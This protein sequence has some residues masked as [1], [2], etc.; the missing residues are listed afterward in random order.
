MRWNTIYKAG[1]IYKIDVINSRS[2]AAQR[3]PHVHN[4]ISK[5]VLMFSDYQA[6][7]FLEPSKKIQIKSL[8]DSGKYVE[9]CNEW[10]ASS[11]RLST[12]ATQ[13]EEMS[14]PW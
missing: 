2:Q 12:R 10:W 13:Q 8:L 9:A 11:A 4:L 6:V 3:K 14:Q 5:L 7:A 1:L